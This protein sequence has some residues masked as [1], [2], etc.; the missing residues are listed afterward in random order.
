M[1]RVFIGSSFTV[2]LIY[3]FICLNI[4]KLKSTHEINFKK[5]YYVVEN[6]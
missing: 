4:S 3:K 2:T 5:Y 1:T 6:P